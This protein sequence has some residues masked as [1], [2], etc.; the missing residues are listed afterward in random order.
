MKGMKNNEENQQAFVVLH[1]PSWFVGLALGIVAAGCS[2]TPVRDGA[3]SWTP[4]SRDIVFYRERGQEKA[5]LFVMNADGGNVRQLTNTPNAAEGYP[6]VSP[7]GRTIA[8]ES[9]AAG[10][11][12]DVWLMDRSG[13]NP[14]RLTSDPSREVAPA[15]SPDGKTI[16]F[17]SDRENPEFDI[18][19]MNA[20]GSDV[21]R[22]TTGHTNWFP[23][24]SPDGTRV[25]MHTGRDVHVINVATGASARLTT[26]PAN[27]MYPSWSPD[28]KRLIFMSWRN[29]VT[30]L[31]AMNA[32]GSD[33]Q[34]IAAAPAGSSIDPRASPDGTRVVFVVTPSKSPTEEPDP[35]ASS[36]IYVLDVAT[37]TI[38]RVS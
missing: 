1:C 16:I 37:A 11:N 26:D 6:S 8:Y 33:Q 21:A 34:Q 13:F 17:M 12:F 24:Y 25:A 14:R 31:F 15:W 2:S 27:G 30:Q 9:D 38:K 5:D 4:D 36:Q 23:Q 20:D 18:Y 22:L 7:D 35:D 29:G 10:G 19:T 28:G 3:P 32:D